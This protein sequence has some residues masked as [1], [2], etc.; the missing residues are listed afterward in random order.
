MLGRSAAEWRLLPVMAER[1]AVH[2]L[3]E[4]GGRVQQRR[5]MF[6]VPSA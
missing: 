3:G 4:N 2:Q 6:A 1:F 5:Q